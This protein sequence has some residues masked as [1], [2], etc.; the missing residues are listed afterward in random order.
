M[1]SC[2]SGAWKKIRDELERKYIDQGSSW[3]FMLCDLDEMRS[4][5]EKRP[6]RHNKVIETLAHE[7]EKREPSLLQHF[8]RGYRKELR[9]NSH[10]INVKKRIQTVYV[11]STSI[12]SEGLRP[13]SEHERNPFVA[14]YEAGKA[15]NA[16]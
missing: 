9:R 1:N 15:A 4:V 13:V 7:I 3:S 16:R 5:S 14:R 8:Y 12:G 10:E 11:S 2:D 6:S